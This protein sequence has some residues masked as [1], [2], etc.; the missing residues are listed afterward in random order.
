[1]AKDFWESFADELKRE[2]ERRP[3]GKG[4]KTLDELQAI[5]KRHR[6]N[7]GSMLMKGVRAGKLERFV[8][9]TLRNGK[10][11]TAAWYRPKP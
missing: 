10:L 3:T 11:K 4:W 9:R 2:G 1:M 7:T 5:F 6:T 8:G